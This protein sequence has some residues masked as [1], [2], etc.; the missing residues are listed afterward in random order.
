MIIEDERPKP[1]NIIPIRP[2]IEIPVTEKKKPYCSK[3]CRQ[4]T[5]DTSKRMLFCRDCGCAIEAFDWLLQW[6]RDGDNRL[7]YLKDLS[8]KVSAKRDEYEKLN[9]LVKQARQKARKAG[10]PSVAIDDLKFHALNPNYR[11]ASET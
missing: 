5:C 9:E 11:R 3:G 2:D 6:A 8:E 10:V 7:S 4:V 1:E